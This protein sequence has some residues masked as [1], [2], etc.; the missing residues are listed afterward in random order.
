MKKDLLM[1]EGNLS[2]GYY[3]ELYSVKEVKLPEEL[4]GKKIKVYIKEDTDE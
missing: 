2:E 1:I 3:D 4:W